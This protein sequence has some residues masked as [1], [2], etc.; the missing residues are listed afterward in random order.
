[1][2]LTH[3]FYVVNEDRDVVAGPF[4]N[5]RKAEKAGFDLGIP[6][7]ILEVIDEFNNFAWGEQP[8]DLTEGFYV[9]QEGTR[10]VLSGPHK[11]AQKAFKAG[12]EL[13]EPFA[14]LEVLEEFNNYAWGE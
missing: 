12:E 6:F 10:D 3:G 13:G 8:M 5:S 14:I 1:M 7:A 9:I 4:H 11:N 2:D